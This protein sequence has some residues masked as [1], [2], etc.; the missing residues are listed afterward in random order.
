MDDDARPP[1]GINLPPACNHCQHDGGNSPRTE[2]GENSED[3]ARVVEELERLGREKLVLLKFLE[4]RATPGVD[5]SAG[6][7]KTLNGKTEAIRALREV[8][9][10]IRMVESTLALHAT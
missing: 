2:Y 8:E 4:S 3:R 5:T 1:Q 10:K 6:L 9:E 7:S